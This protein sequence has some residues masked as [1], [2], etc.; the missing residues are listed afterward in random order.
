MVIEKRTSNLKTRGREGAGQEPMWGPRE[1]E[2]H[3]TV[4]RRPVAA[5]R[6]PGDHREAEG[7]GL[8]RLDLETQPWS[9][10]HAPDMHPSSPSWV[11]ELLE[12]GDGISTIL[13]SPEPCRS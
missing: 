12:K 4:A 7:Q 2:V 3:G 5:E 11:A 13:T 10:D 6:K 1:R 9:H 8:A